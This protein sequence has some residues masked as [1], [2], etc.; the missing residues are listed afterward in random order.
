MK[1]CTWGNI[2]SA[3][4][5]KTDG[6]GELQIAMLA[7]VLAGSGHEVI[8]IDFNAPQEFI[9]NDGIKV[10]QV[11]GWNDG[12]PF[13][14]MFT[15][16]IPR[17][18]KSL[19]SQ[20]ADIYYC[21]IRDFRHI[22]ALWAARKTNGKFVLQLASDLDALNFRKRLKHDYLT[23]IGGLWWFVRALL[24]EMLFPGLLRK[25]DL[26][27][28]QHEGQKDVLRQKGI[29]S[30]IFNNLIDL[31]T[32]PELKTS[33]KK[34]FC[35][36]GALDRRKGFAEFFELVNKAPDEHFKVI[37]QPRDKTGHYYFEKL[38]S[39]KNVTLY[40]KLSH[41]ET[42]K[43]ISES[44]ALVSTSPMEGFPNIF[45]EAW[46]CGIPVLTLS[47]D[48]GSVIEKE[49]LGIVA[50]GNLDYLAGSLKKVNES[51]EF[52]ERARQYVLQNHAL[53][54]NKVKEINLLFK[55]I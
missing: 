5:G 18:Y 33:G 44:M 41:S 52:S 51:K 26:V 11:K 38:K 55:N 34:D 9:S 28:A 36:V 46:A 4:A 39:Y 50:H 49:K 12:V 54:E 15:H 3:L 42:I 37:G 45:V 20:K 29:H 32:L 25:A 10:L 47:F 21:Q 16:R 6:G 14:R 35:Y 7:K 43:H 24:T 30:V 27:L 31:K 19:K 2:A 13:L 17:L 1:F 8:V 53:T 22:L 40:G 48:P 23:D